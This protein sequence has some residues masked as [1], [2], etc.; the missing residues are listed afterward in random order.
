M[1][2]L[3]KIERK[4]SP[5]DLARSSITIVVFLLL[6]LPIRL[7]AEEQIVLD[8]S[9]S[10]ANPI[11]DIADLPELAAIVRMEQYQFVIFPGTSEGLA[12]TPRG[13]NLSTRVSETQRYFEIY[14][15]DKRIVI[16]RFS[17]KFEV[18]VQGAEAYMGRGSCIRIRER[19]F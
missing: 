2:Q 14:F 18:W 1:R 9:V 3:Q 11:L 16:N 12:T 13:S 6:I 4:I 7:W 8:C 10:E 17:G 5:L 19:K 15:E